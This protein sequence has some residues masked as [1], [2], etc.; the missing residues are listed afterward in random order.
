MNVAPVPHPTHFPSV[1]SHFCSY[2]QS[3]PPDFTSVCSPESPSAS[4]K[5]ATSKKPAPFPEHSCIRVPLSSPLYCV[6]SA[7]GL[8]GTRWG[9]VYLSICPRVPPLPLSSSPASHPCCSR[10]V[11]K[12][13]VCQ[14]AYFSF[15]FYHTFLEENFLLIKRSKG[16]TETRKHFMATDSQ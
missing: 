9:T 14:F 5:A 12:I 4:L 1:D 16:W 7:H 10:T 11:T 13:L 8:V 2:P 3:A 6:T 15:V